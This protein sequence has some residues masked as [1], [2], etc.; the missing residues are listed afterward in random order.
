VNAKSRAAPGNPAPLTRTTAK[1][2]EVVSNST[3]GADSEAPSVETPPELLAPTIA[4][5]R[6]IFFPQDPEGKLLG[7]ER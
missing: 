4:Q 2:P 7:G 3:G 5:M 1:Q 6:R